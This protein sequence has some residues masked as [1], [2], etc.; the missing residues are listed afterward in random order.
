MSARSSGAIRCH[1][2]PSGIPN[3]SISRR[4]NPSTSPAAATAHTFISPSPTGA[5]PA[6]PSPKISRLTRPSCP[7]APGA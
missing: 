3:L 7:A 2:T 6:Y 5:I 1:S 4:R